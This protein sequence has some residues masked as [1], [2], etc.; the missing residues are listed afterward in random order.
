MI[1]TVLAVV[2]AVT[3][4]ATTV[5]AVER[6]GI[7]RTEQTIT[8]DLESLDEQALTLLNT[9]EVAEGPGAKRTV[10]L[11]IPEGG[12]VAAGTDRITIRTTNITY[13]I[14]GKAKQTV[15]PRAPIVRPEDA[16][17]LVFASSGSHEIELQPV[18]RDE[19]RKIMVTA[20]HERFK[21]PGDDAPE[22]N[23]TIE[24]PDGQDEQPPDETDDTESE[25]SDDQSIW[26]RLREFIPW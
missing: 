14:D 3:L 17:P 4:I 16:G 11:T 12:I 6:A 20:L 23:D 5:P 1:R 7:D 8:N 21:D 18:W 15:R 10:S 25:E 19:H 22:N 24:L 13:K 26:D 2:L 9:E